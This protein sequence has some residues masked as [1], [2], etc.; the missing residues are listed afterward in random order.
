MSLL[1]YPGSVS[2]VVTALCFTAQMTLFTLLVQKTKQNLPCKSIIISYAS[3]ICYSLY[4]FNILIMS[5]IAETVPPSSFN[6]AA[7]CS[8]RYTAPSFFLLGK[9]LMLLFYT[10]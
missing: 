6:G 4:S 3:V 10:Y 9:I 1:I 8:Y 5:I 7:L 2:A